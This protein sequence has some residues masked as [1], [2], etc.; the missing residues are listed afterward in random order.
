MF[1][2]QPNTL[3][4]RAILPRSNGTAWLRTGFLLVLLFGARPTP[5]LE[6]SSERRCCHGDVLNVSRA[7]DLGL[8]F[9]FFVLGVGL[10][11]ILCQQG[12]EFN[13]CDIGAGGAAGVWL[14]SEHE[15]LVSLQCIGFTHSN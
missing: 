9:G 10:N 6:G 12:A 8:R 4:A 3:S 2:T 14:A 5:I 15:M 11:Q 13:Q 7:K 1:F